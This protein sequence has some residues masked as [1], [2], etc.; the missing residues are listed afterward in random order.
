MKQDQQ[1]TYE[2]GR[3]EI[4]HFLVFLESFG[5]QSR[6]WSTQCHLNATILHLSGHGRS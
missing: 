3:V 2:L 5:L 4:L 6:S 1:W